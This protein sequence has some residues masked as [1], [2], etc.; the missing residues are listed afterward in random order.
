MFGKMMNR[1]FKLQDEIRLVVERDDLD[2]VQSLDQQL[3]ECWEE[4]LAFT[5]ASNDET[6]E[7]AEF[8][9]EIMTQNLDQT[10]GE[11][12]AKAKIIDLVKNKN[13]PT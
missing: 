7:M 11:L 13:T 6:V 1:F 4:I 9:L 5:P 12:A 3:I 10:R 2:K 8:L